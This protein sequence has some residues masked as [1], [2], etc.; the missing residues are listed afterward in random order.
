MCVC[1]RVSLSLP[2]PLSRCCL[3]SW[4]VCLCNAKLLTTKLR[5]HQRKRVL[6]HNDKTARR[7]TGIQAKLCCSQK[8]QGFEHVRQLR[9]GKEVP[10]ARTVLEAEENYSDVLGLQWFFRSHLS[11]TR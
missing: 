6:G 2:L 11:D 9:W 7:E 10:D 8:E 4:A 3:I 5:V 1:V